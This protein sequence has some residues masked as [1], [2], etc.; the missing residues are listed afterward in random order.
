[1]KHSKDKSRG[2]ENLW[3]LNITR[4][5]KCCNRTYIVNRIHKLEKTRLNVWDLI[6]EV[7]AWLPLTHQTDPDNNVHGANMGPIWVLSAPGGSHVG[8]MNLAIRGDAWRA[9]VRHNRQHPNL[10]MDMYMDG[11]N[12][13]HRPHMQYQGIN[14]G[15]QCTYRHRLGISSKL[16]TQ[17]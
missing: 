8:P 5:V 16:I 4:L 10:K 14:T 3:N 1:M 11:W 12:N 7:V 15:S 13:P 9:G 6:S 2:T 17:L